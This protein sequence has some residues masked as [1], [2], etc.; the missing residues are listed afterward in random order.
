MNAYRNV[1]AFIAGALAFAAATSGCT[2]A[3]P[4]TDASSTVEVT[5]LRPVRVQTYDQPQ[6][7]NRGAELRGKLIA[8]GTGNPV[9]SLELCLWKFSGF[10]Q[11]EGTV[12]M[13]SNGT[14]KLSRT[15]AGGV[16]TF[17]GVQ[18]GRYSVTPTSVRF[19]DVLD[20]NGNPALVEILPGMKV[21]D[22]GEIP[23]ASR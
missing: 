17:A 19:S 3:K 14:D 7:E 21:V 23:V 10:T 5:I 18:S 13:V 9:G 12:R 1:I 20:H 11:S 15:S 16:F 4:L 6:R 2:S 22:L 8:R